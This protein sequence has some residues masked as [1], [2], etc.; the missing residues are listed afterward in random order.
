MRRKPIGI[1]WLGAVLFGL[2]GCQHPPQW[3]RKSDVP[4]KPP[5]HEEYVLPP[6]DDARFSSP[7]SYPKETL[8]TGQLK[9][10]SSKP[11]DLSR[12]PGRFGATGPGMGGF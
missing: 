8:D 7:P 2:L 4:P 12:T 1:C 6:T 11:G 5:L 3:L 9:K 10:D